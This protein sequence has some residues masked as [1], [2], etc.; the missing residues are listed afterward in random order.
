MQGLAGGLQGLV[1]GHLQ[2]IGGQPPQARLLVAGMVSGVLL[3]VQLPEQLPKRIHTLVPAV[4][5]LAGLLRCCP[6][7]SA[8]I[9]LGHGAAPGAPADGA[10]CYPPVPG[11]P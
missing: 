6:G 4:A 10:R 5:A 1:R 9:L 3:Q 7:A 2:G 11:T 8:S